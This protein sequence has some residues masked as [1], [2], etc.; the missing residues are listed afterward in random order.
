MTNAFLH[1]KVQKSNKYHEHKNTSK[2]RMKNLHNKKTLLMRISS[3]TGS[4]GLGQ[5]RLGGVR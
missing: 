1:G 3:L 5:V 4:V 2:I